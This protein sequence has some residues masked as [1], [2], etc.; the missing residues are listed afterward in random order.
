MTGTASHRVF[1]FY[2][3]NQ[4]RISPRV[5]RIGPLNTTTALLES[6]TKPCLL[7]TGSEH[8]SLLVLVYFD[9]YVVQLLEWFYANFE[10]TSYSNTVVRKF[11][12]HDVSTCYSEAEQRHPTQ[13]TR[14]QLIPHI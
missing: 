2:L 6:R 8:R 11:M 10:L 12:V 1:Y 4:S 13:P 5:L 3:R 9:L 14:W 7:S